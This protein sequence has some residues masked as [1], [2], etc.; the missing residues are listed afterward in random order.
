MKQDKTGGMPPLNKSIGIYHKPLWLQQLR[1]E[2]DDRVTPDFLLNLQ[3]NFGN[4]KINNQTCS[5]HNDGLN[6]IFARLGSLDKFTK[7]DEH[8]VQKV[9]SKAA[10]RKKNKEIEKDI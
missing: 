5:I 7:V 10:N 8:F 4:G 3:N 1:S 2:N 6:K 9:G